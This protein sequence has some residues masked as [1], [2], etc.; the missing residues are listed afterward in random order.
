MEYPSEHNELSIK[1]PEILHKLLDR[2]NEYAKEPRDMQDQGY[3]PDG[4]PEFKGAC[5]Y[6]KEHGMY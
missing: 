6:M 5:N 4:I 3:H 1:E 2:Y